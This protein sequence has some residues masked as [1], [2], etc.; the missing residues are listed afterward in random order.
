MEKE[1]AKVQVL[2]RDSIF[3]A[4]VLNLLEVGHSSGLFAGSLL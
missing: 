1:N 2:W 4:V 3:S